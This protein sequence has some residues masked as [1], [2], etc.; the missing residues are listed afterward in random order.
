MLK[1]KTNKGPLLQST[2]CTWALALMQD[3]PM[4]KTRLLAERA[5]SVDSQISN[6]RENLEDVKDHVQLRHRQFFPCGGVLSLADEPL[7]I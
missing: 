2:F 1:R 3:M 6:D 7:G 4:W 5:T